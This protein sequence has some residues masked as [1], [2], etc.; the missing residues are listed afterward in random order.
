[1]TVGIQ[2]DYVRKNKEAFYQNFFTEIQGKI[3]AYNKML[4]YR[5]I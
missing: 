3:G 4:I 1:L 5:M 2:K